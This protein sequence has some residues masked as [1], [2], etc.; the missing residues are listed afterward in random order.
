MKKIFYVFSIDY[1][2]ISHR[3]A[4]V[5]AAI[6]NR[7]DVT[8]VAQDTG[9]RKEIESMGAKFIDLPINRVGTNILEELKT[10]FF[11]FKL[12]K[13]HK[14][15]LVHHISIKVVL[16]GA[17]AARLA[18]VKNVVNA[19]NGL[20]VFFSTGEVDSLIKK[21]FMQLIR[22]SNNRKKCVTIFQNNEDKHFFLSNK[23]LKESQIRII[24][25]SG[26]DLNEFKFSEPPL[27][28]PLKIVF[29]SRMV[30]EKGV[31]DII[32]AAKLL[33]NKYF[34]KIQ[35]LLCGL[36]ETNPNAVSESYLQSECDGD[37]IQYL[38]HCT[39][40]KDILS[41]SSI[42]LLPSYYRE[43]IPKSLIEAT[44][45]GR[46]IITTNSVGCK[47]TV[48]DG[49]N[50]FIVPIKSPEE[51]ANKIEALVSNLDLI[52]K[53]GKESRLLSE[54]EFS[55]DIVIDKHLQIYSELINS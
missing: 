4:V 19:V 20:G 29:T 36:I 13:N 11:L 26:V 54:K 37:Y 46:P 51:I 52:S 55:I 25:G 23:A 5:Q 50:G 44:A 35:F 6:Q 2:L 32:N 38:G 47:E 22:F 49:K 17:L 8:V 3:K 30:K 28:F 31:E 27:E 42:V 33:K 18:K 53:M 48:E 14:P 40:I 21:I 24:R 41:K 45:I 9:Y 15:D 39:N 1:Q 12:Y 7:Y 16:W 43:G 10:F 34:D